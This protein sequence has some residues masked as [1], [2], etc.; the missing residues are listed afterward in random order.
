MDDC[1]YITH[2]TV[3]LMSNIP[4]FL[5][6]IIDQMSQMISKT[7]INIVKKTRT[8]FASYEKYKLITLHSDRR[9]II[10]HC[11]DDDY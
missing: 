7:M 10:L 8:Y 3:I 6:P 9:N 4:S 5:T 1:F 2:I 11:D